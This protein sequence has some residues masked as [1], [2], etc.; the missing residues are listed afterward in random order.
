MSQP[1]RDEYLP[2]SWGQCHQL[3]SDEEQLVHGH[4]ETEQPH[5]SLAPLLGEPHQSDVGATGHGHHDTDLLQTS[6]WQHTSY[7]TVQCHQTDVL[8]T[9]QILVLNVS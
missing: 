7:L 8:Q 6:S 4:T 2:A 5:L 1:I 3:S 9:N